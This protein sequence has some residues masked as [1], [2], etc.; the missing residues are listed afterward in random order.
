M[1]LLIV[2]DACVAINKELNVRK[3]MKKHLHSPV[4]IRWVKGRGQKP[5]FSV[6]K[7]KFYPLTH[8]IHKYIHTQSG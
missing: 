2:I 7:R 1:L 6:P 3:K 8:A 4:V 5:F